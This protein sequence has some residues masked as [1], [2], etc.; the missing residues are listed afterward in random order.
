MDVELHGT[1]RASF[2]KTVNDVIDSMQEELFREKDFRF[3][4]CL[5]TNV[6]LP[7]VKFDSVFIFTH[8]IQHF[9][10]SGLGLR[11]ICDWTMHL[12]RFATEMDK[13]HDLGFDET[14][15]QFRK[16]DERRT[17]HKIRVFPSSQGKIPE[18]TSSVDV[19]PL[20]LVPKEHA[21]SAMRHYRHRS[22]RSGK[23]TIITSYEETGRGRIFPDTSHI[24][25][26]RGQPVKAALSHF[27]GNLI[28][29]LVIFDCLSYSLKLTYRSRRS[30]VR[31][32]R[33]GRKAEA[34][35]PC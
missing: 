28:K 7:S 30:E 17:R 11:Q 25:Y 3:W 22:G 8:F 33:E 1:A 35:N 13:E 4:E 21:E 26:E 16:E 24:E 34:R 14:F 2:G 18:R 15:R 20:H 9:Y 23:G 6:S 29:N 31:Q 32:G 19:T 12:H 5:G 10:H 27:L